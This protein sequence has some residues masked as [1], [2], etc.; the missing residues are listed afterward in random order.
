MKISVIIITY[1]QEKVVRR[2]IDSVLLQANKN[3][4]LEII[5]SDDCSF[6]STWSIIKSYS[7]LH[8]RLFKIKRNSKNLGIYDNYQSTFSLVTGDIIFSLAGDDEFNSNLFYSTHKYVIR[9]QLDPHKEKFNIIFDNIIVYPD[10]K[11]KIFKNY[12]I[13][14]YPAKSLKIRNLI[15]NQPMGESSLNFRCRTYVPGPPKRFLFF[16]ESLV[17][18]QP[19]LYATS[20]YY[21]PRVGLKYFASLGISTKLG[22]E[23]YIHSK[24]EFLKFL[25]K[26][27]IL[28][29]K[30]DYYWVKFELAR[31]EHRQY[32]NIRSLIKYIYSFLTIMGQQYSLLLIKKTISNKVFILKHYFE[33]WTV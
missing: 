32:K 23:Y 6:D 1:N 12:L 29:T 26:S 31:V 10:G 25:I 13:N 17:E 28:N 9:K 19:H 27:H 15:K 14:K 18:L 21:I 22:D 30:K 16:Q 5:V 20:T 33:I 3:Y 7:I 11:T 24:K 8:P 2:A 4:S